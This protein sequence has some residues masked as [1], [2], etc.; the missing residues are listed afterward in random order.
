MSIVIAV[1]VKIFGSTKSNV[2]LG[3]L[4]LSGFL[5]T[6]NSIQLYSYV[7]MEKLFSSEILLIF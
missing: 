5:L 6:E 7:M 3:L 1:L 4:I 2:T